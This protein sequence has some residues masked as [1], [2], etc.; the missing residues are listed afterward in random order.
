MDGEVTVAVVGSRVLV[1]VY[2]NTDGELVTGR[3]DD[4][5][6]TVAVID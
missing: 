6:D 5:G 3:D 1:M 2:G 4:V